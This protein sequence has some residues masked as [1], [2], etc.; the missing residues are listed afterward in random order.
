MRMYSINTFNIFH[1]STNINGCGLAR[2]YF[3]E[4]PL[5]IKNKTFFKQ[6]F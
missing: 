5:T 2:L 6:F 3:N 4:L 1:L